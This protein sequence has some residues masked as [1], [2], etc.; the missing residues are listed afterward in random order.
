MLARNADPY[1][2]GGAHPDWVYGNQ[3]VFYN[4]GDRLILTD[5][6]GDE[7]DRVDWYPESGMPVPN[8]QSL[9]LR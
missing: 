3:I 1:L 6:E 4:L 9:A 7:H 5:A 8:G 2:N